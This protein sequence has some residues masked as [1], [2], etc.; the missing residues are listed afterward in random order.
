LQQK[1]LLKYELNEPLNQDN[2]AALFTWVK[3]TGVQLVQINGQ[4]KYGRIKLIPLFQSAGELNKFCLMVT[5][6][7][8]NWGFTDAM[9]VTQYGALKAIKLLNK[10]KIQ[11]G[12]QI[13]VCRSTNKCEFFIDAL[14]PLVK[15]DH[16][17]LIQESSCIRYFVSS[18]D[19]IEVGWLTPNIK[20]ELHISSMQAILEIMSSQCIMF[21]DMPLAKNLPSLKKPVKLGYAKAHLPSMGL[22]KA[23]QMPLVW[24]MMKRPSIGVQLWLAFRKPSCSTEAG[25]KVLW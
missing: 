16:L 6:N 9:Y 7:G 18:G 13:P 22:S 15:E 3:D 23:S 19:Q 8:L 21:A 10:Y 24:K 4:R 14:T 1:W 2:K 20:Q 12:H 5:F 25:S 17:L 11:K